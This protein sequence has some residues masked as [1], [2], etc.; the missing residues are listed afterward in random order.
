MRFN[1]KTPSYGTGFDRVFRPETLSHV[2]TFWDNG[3]FDRDTS[4]RR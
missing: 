1:S 4:K 2:K 3:K